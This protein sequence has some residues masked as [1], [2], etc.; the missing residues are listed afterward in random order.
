[1]LKKVESE[2]YHNKV[3]HSADLGIISEC[4]HNAVIIE[5]RLL[6]IRGDA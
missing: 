1:M 2:F 6:C 4:N 5:S 3:A